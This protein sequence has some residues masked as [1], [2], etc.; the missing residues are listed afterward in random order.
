MLSAR[1]GIT[2]W[3]LTVNS[4]EQSEEKQGKQWSLC[5]KVHYGCKEGPAVAMNPSKFQGRLVFC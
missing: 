3:Q 1:S 5:L 2:Y 4:R